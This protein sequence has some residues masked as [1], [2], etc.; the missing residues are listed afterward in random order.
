MPVHLTRHCSYVAAPAGA[1]TWIRESFRDHVAGIPGGPRDVDGQAWALVRAL[2][3]NAATA[4]LAIPRGEPDAWLGWAVTM[5]GR[6][7]FAYMRLDFRRH[8]IGLAMVGHVLDRTPI[9]VAYW[10]SDARAMA[11]HGIPIR[12]SIEAYNDLLYFVRGTGR[13][14]TNNRRGLNETQDLIVH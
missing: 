10:T 7:V 11:D 14:T 9:D 13:Q 12:Y 3:T 5:R 1:R 8:G 4:T 6:L 2:S